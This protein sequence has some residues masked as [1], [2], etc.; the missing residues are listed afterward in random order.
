MRKAP[1]TRSGRWNARAPRGGE[2]RAPRGHKEAPPVPPL[3]P[4]PRDG[5]RGLLLGTHR[6]PA[7][8]V[9]ELPEV[10]PQRA[11]AL[12]V[13]GDVHGVLG[14]ERERGRGEQ[15]PENVAAPQGAGCEAAPMA[16]CGVS[17][18]PQAVWGRAPPCAQG[19]HLPQHLQLAQLLVVVLRVLPVV[20]QDKLGGGKAQVRA[21]PRATD[22]EPEE[23]AGR[24]P[25]GLRGVQGGWGGTLGQGV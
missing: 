24:A 2:K 5:D 22:R 25:G 12:E 10:F 20:L 3:P 1:R 8:Q 21:R 17:A 13:P 4:S 16:S 6:D 19:A 23:A 11:A 15:E 9:V 18:T 7:L 14:G